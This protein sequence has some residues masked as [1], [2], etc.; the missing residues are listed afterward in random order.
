MDIDASTY[1]T[2]GDANATHTEDLPKQLNPTCYV[3]NFQGSCDSGAEELVKDD[4]GIVVNG[5]LYTSKED[6]PL[7]AETTETP[8][9][10]TSDPSS[11]S[12]MTGVYTA[13]E[14][15]DA[16]AWNPPNSGLVV[17]IAGILVLQVV[18]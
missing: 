6:W 12:D 3:R 11:T 14:T 16:A 17:A 4:K 13:T 5:I 2:T 7:Q 9:T 8:T 15:P 18:A 1:N 10:S